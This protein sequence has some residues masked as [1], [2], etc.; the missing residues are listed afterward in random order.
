MY[1]GVNIISRNS[2]I[3]N[4][5]ILLFFFIP[6]LIKILSKFTI[7]KNVTKTFLTNLL[8]NILAKRKLNILKEGQIGDIRLE[9]IA[10]GNLFVPWEDKFK[11]KVSKKVTVRVNEQKDYYKRPLKKNVGVKVKVKK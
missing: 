2:R 10:E 3:I 11:V 5:L 8:E 6:I 1:F 9:V 7:S 4:L